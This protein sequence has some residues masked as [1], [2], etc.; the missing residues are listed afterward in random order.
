MRNPQT[1]ANEIKNNV[2]AIAKYGCCAFT[3]LWAV[4][5]DPDIDS[6]AIEILNDAI[7]AGVIEKDCT[8]K[9]VDFYKWLIGRE[10]KVEFREIKS[11]KE[12]KNVKIGVVVVLSLLASSL[13]TNASTP[14]SLTNSKAASTNC[15]LVNFGFGGILY[16]P[17]SYPIFV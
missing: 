2:Q 14:C 16:L 5:V 17:N 11:L 3:A 10:I 1:V 7:N 9:W 4:G 15:S 8:V 12:L 13:A 6:A